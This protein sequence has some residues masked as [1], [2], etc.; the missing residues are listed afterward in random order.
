MNLSGQAL[1]AFLKKNPRV[2][3]EDILIVHDDLEHKVGTARI[4]VEGSAEYLLS[5]L[6]VTME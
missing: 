2:K 1:S 5:H 6:G 4:K 3:V